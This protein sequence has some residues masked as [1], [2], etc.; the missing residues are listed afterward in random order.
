[1][2]KERL[3]SMEC[4]VWAGKNHLLLAEFC[5]GELQGL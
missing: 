4:L 2:W 1:M 3:H 5:L